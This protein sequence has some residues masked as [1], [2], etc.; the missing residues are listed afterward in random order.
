VLKIDYDR[1]SN[2]GWTIRP[3]LDE[4]VQVADGYYLGNVHFKWWWGRWQL[5]AYF[6]L[7]AK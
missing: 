7:Q 5:I 4:L 2:P 6:S 3:I 1:P